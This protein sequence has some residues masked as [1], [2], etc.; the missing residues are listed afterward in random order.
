V[1]LELRAD[2]KKAITEMQRVGESARKLAADAQRAAEQE[3]AAA[4]ESAAEAKAAAEEKVA[5]A[6]EAARA[7]V[8]AA[9]EVAAARAEAAAVEERAIEQINIA[10]AHGAEAAKAAA[11]EQE[12]AAKRAA[13]AIEDAEARQ[14]AAARA[15]ATAQEEAAAAITAA[16]DREIEA[17]GKAGAA[18]EAMAAKHAAAMKSMVE[19]ANVVSGFS[20]LAAG[21]IGT[22]AVEEAAKFQKATELL[23]TAGGESKAQ[24]ANVRTGIMG[25][26]ADTGTATD[27]LAEGMYVMEKAGYRGADG[28]KVLRAAAE[29]A[30]AENVDL[31]TMTQAVTDVMLD[32]G[33]GADQAVSVTNGLV[34]ASGL[35]KTT[36]QDFANSMAAIVPTASTAGLSFAQVGGALATMTQHG[37]SAQ[38]SSQNLA[39]LLT[40]LERPSQVASKALQSMGVDVTDL[41][42]NLGDENGGRGLLGSLQLIDQQIKS[43]MGADG[44]VVQSTMKKSADA[45][46]D[47]HKIIAQM[48]PEL[49]QLSQGFMDGTV[50]QTQYQKA[51]KG[52]GGSA[53]ALGGQFLNLAKSTLGV[54][55]LLKSGSPALMTYVGEWNRAA[56]GITG[57]RTA[58]MLLMNDSAEFQHNI[59]AIT[60]A[61]E[62]NGQHI[63]TWADTQQT[64][65]VQLDM[66]K[67]A[68][69]NLGIELGDKLMPAALGLVHGVTDVVHG[70]EQGNPVLLTAAGII[71][72]ALLIST[73]NLGIK[74]GKT[75][76][77]VVTNLIEMGSSAITMGQQFHLGFANAELA[78]EEG[79]TRMTRFGGA[80]KGALPTLGG[81]GAAATA[82]VIGLQVLN[83][84]SQEVT[85][86]TDKMKKALVDFSDAGSAV[87]KLEL[88]QQFTKWRT[89]AGM[90]TV[91]VSNLDD[92]IKQMTHVDGYGQ[93][94]NFFDGIR[95]A[96]GATKSD[97]GQLQDRFKSVG[98]QLGAMVSNGAVDVAAK[99]FDNLAE[100]FVKNGKTA[101]DALNAMP[102]YQQALKDNAAAAGVELSQQELLDYAMGKV[103][104]KMLNAMDS[105]EK[106]TDAAGKIQPITPALKKSLDDAGVSAEGLV[107][108]LDKVKSGMEA[109]GLA[110]VNQRD[111]QVKVNQSMDAAKKALDDVA[112]AQK[113]AAAQGQDL[114]KALN[115][116]GTD[117]DLTTQAGQML[118]EKYE[119]VLR[120]NMD[121]AN[122]VKG[123]GAD[124]QKEFQD[125]LNTTYKN[126]VDAGHQMGITGTHADDLARQVMG[127]PPGVNIQSWMSDYAL[128][129]ANQTKAAA[130]RLNGTVAHVAVQ[131]DVNNSAALDPKSYAAALSASKSGSPVYEST[132]GFI[133]R[134]TGGRVLHLAGG[135]GATGLVVGPGTGTSD[136][137]PAM[138]SNGEYVI[139]EASVQ[140]YGVGY[141]EAVNRGIAPNPASPKGAPVA[142]AP[143]LAGGDHRQFNV[144]VNAI[145]N[146]SPRQIAS[147]L[148]QELHQLS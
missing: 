37:E 19:A 119:A 104:E 82:A 116:Q 79:A 120:S 66:T 110:T 61:E 55:D 51:F 123:T 5:A 20:L 26:A 87:G 23:V 88:D 117:F 42:K 71:G 27:Q 113:Q 80:V 124:A 15:A 141:L 127:I 143:S 63:A 118:N 31:A 9:E 6:R 58:L 77:G 39:N 24:L 13:I 18:S 84:M 133:H 22:A 34:A 148:G 59:D 101:Q 73:V 11:D 57:A 131:I 60:K 99:A 107:T 54:N 109:A 100:K 67:Q 93:F 49:A 33:K 12:A 97:V 65:A 25:I 47:L 75:A 10:L 130:D 45:T 43:H 56:G 96:V 85:I 48:P 137:V 129:M 74:M 36:M 94:S 134:A 86:D 16:E 30:K 140:K 92:A 122:S 32:Y 68:A 44:M 14:A 114:G 102:G 146:A 1:L 2:G 125:R 81:L 69:A 138:L 121:Y 91:N 7:E 38:Q 35:A 132:G 98:D 105:T 41:S 142:V 8:A 144:T 115:A 72:G 126:L 83:S 89:S 21:I 62:Q 90:T 29:G 135:G 108:D 4:R 64:F 145:T 3:A 40:Q 112:E 70:F 46:A 76:V 106:Y 53:N 52:M 17:Y 139:K 95:G 147:G 136:Q 103:P 28:L 50:S 78:A 111:A 128:N